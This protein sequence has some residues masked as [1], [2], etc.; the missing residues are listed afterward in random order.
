MPAVSAIG[1]SGGMSA[2]YAMYSQQLARSRQQMNQAANAAAARSAAMN[3]SQPEAPV[4]PV[5][6]VGRVKP[7]ETVRMP[8]AV[9]DTPLPT[10][11]DLNNAADNLAR[12]QIQYP[13]DNAEA[14]NADTRDLAPETAGEAED[15]SSIG[16]DAQDKTSAERQVQTEEAQSQQGMNMG[17][18]TN[19]MNIAGIS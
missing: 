5:S 12:M 3:P 17:V 4:E 19:L 9:Q 6:A 18:H 14:E 2:L 7:D 1:A 8:V 13:E 11:E 10:V 15:T 16:E